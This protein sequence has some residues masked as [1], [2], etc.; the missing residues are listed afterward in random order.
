MGPLLAALHI[1]VAAHLAAAGASPPAPAQLEAL[2][3]DAAI[4]ARIDLIHI[5]RAIGAARRAS[6]HL[7][8]A[9][10]AAGALSRAQIGFDVL[11]AD[12]WRDA[13]VDLAA[14]I[15]VSALALDRQ[16]AEAALVAGS[17]APLYWRS[18][19][20]LPI[21]DA[22]A[23]DEAIRRAARAVPGVEPTEGRRPGPLVAGTI[24]G[25]GAAVF[26]RRRDRVLIIDVLLPFAGGEEE[27]SRRA[28]AR[29]GTGIAPA[30]APVFEG[31]GL[32]L[33]TS[34]ERMYAALELFERRARARRVAAPL[35]FERPLP[36]ATDTA[37]APFERLAAR[38]ALG[39]V[40]LRVAVEEDAAAVRA[41]WRVRQTSDLTEYLAPATGGL[42][43]PPD[44]ELALGWH[45]E[46]PAR[47]AALPRP[48]ALDRP[49]RDVRRHAARCG[50]A[51][52]AVLWIFGWPELGGSF[53]A[54]LHR[55]GSRAAVLARAVGPGAAA[56]RTLET[57]LDRIVGALAV[58]THA[59]EGASPAADELLDAI[60][61]ARRPG[62]ASAEHIWGRG[63]LRPFRERAD[64]E[65]ITYGAGRGTPS[66][67]WFLGG[68][69]APP[70]SP[71]S[72]WGWLRADGGRALEHARARAGIPRWLRLD[73]RALGS[74]RAIASAPDGHI[75]LDVEL[76]LR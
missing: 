22:A 3:R 33:W 21:A 23:A 25:L 43:T 45:I 59:G 31:P 69:G 63:R 49:L 44:A 38:G 76:A 24:E 56:L 64:G 20:A 41:R 74:L 66:V 12:A 51:G 18:R 26:A 28:A 55:V 57:D 68:D 37:C 13:G 67:A 50:A 71:P 7:D 29:P 61:G 27:A 58:A 1:A 52:Q 42:A 14:P 62:P 36:M 32:A 70:A 17:P 72:S 39:D 60:F 2:D 65:A 34:A 54:Q 4:V 53:F 75:A 8:A 35:G 47:L 48:G 46:R 15:A 6:P 9:A 16:A 5:D 11:S 10:T 40:S 30:A 73:A 19:A